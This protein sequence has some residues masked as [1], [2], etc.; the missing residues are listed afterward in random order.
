[1]MGADTMAKTAANAGVDLPAREK[2]VRPERTLRKFLA[3]GYKSIEELL[4]E[5]ETD[6]MII[7]GFDRI[8]KRTI[9]AK[10]RSASEAWCDTW[11]E[12]HEF[13]LDKVAK[14]VAAARACLKSWE[15]TQAEVVAITEPGKEQ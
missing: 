8:L 14:E 12:A 10:K 15:L 3:S 5:G 1:M 11:Q 4:V 13:L 6:T 9:R 7:I 2:P